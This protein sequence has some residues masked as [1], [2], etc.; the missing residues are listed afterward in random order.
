MYLSS[1][2]YTTLMG[3]AAPTDF[4]RLLSHA[5][6]QIDLATLMYFAQCTLADLP[7][8]IL[9]NLRLSVAYQVSYLEQ[10][11]GVAALSEPQDASAS[12]GKFSY[13]KGSA[14]KNSLCDSARRL[15]PFLNAYVRGV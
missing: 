15:I 9:S 10:L 14:P 13:T 7:A 3:V 2:Q 6:S 12:L 8:L 1:E 5:E 11:G 4:T